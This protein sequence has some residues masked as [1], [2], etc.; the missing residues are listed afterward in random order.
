MLGKDLRNRRL[1]LGLSQAQLGLEWGFTRVSVW[2]WE[3]G[4]EDV[5][6]WAS[7]ALRGLEMRLQ[8]G[9]KP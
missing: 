4:A 8:E 1:S 5:A 9:S 7:D 3:S 2:R 6:R